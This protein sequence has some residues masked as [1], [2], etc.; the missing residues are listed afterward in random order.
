MIPTYALCCSAEELPVVW[1]HVPALS[2]GAHCWSA[3][4]VPLTLSAPRSAATG[5]MRDENKMGHG[6]LRGPKVK[7]PGEQVKV[8]GGG[9]GAHPGHP[10]QEGPRVGSRWRSHSEWQG[11]HWQ[12]EG[13]AR[14]QGP[15]H[16]ASVS[17]AL[18]Y[19][20][21]NV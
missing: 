16:D 5:E 18:H 1:A 12:W 9:Q 6:P 4:R 15:S 3:L 19:L 14:G 17:G 13:G 7:T 11:E 10:V 20:N 2:G 8:L 21:H